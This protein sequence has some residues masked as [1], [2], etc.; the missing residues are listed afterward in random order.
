MDLRGGQQSRFDN[1]SESLDCVITTLPSP[2]HHFKGRPTTTNGNHNPGKVALSDVPCA[3]FSSA[4]APL[5]GATMTCKFSRSFGV[6]PLFLPRFCCCWRLFPLATQRFAV[7]IASVLLSHQLHLLSVVFLYLW[8]ASR[9]CEEG[10]MLS[11]I[12]DLSR[13]FGS[14][15]FIHYALLTAPGW[16][17]IATAAEIPETE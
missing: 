11:L 10:N 8:T 7:G 13:S 12:I 1:R 17:R 2:L 15:V 16:T 4:P 3:S 6:K 14:N 9:S 5:F